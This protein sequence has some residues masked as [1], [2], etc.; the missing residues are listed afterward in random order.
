MSQPRSS[1]PVAQ[2][3]ADNETRYLRRQ[4][5]RLLHRSTCDFPGSQPITFQRHHFRELLREDYLVYEKTDGLRYLLLATCVPGDYDA[6]D[7][8][9]IDRRNN[10][11]KPASPTGEVSHIVRPSNP[12]RFEMGPGTETILDGEF[13]L[14]GSGADHTRLF[15]VFDSLAINGQS[16]LHH[17]HSVR[18]QKIKDYLGDECS[19]LLR[20][21]RDKSGVAVRLKT[22]LPS[23]K[24][25]D[26][27]KTIVPHLPYANDGLVF[28]NRESPYEFGTHPSTLKWKRASSTTLDFR[29][30]APPCSSPSD[31]NSFELQIHLGRG[32]HRKFASLHV[33]IDESDANRANAM[34]AHGKVIEC[35]CDGTGLWKPKMLPDG[36]FKTRLDKSRANHIV[37]AKD[38]LQYLQNP[39]TEDELAASGEA[40]RQA[41]KTRRQW[42]EQ[43][44]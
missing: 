17:S 44:L 41:W 16:I 20:H 28:V 24:A 13:V 30:L 32:V 10:Y 12:T 42:R 23:Y 1:L 5:A 26:M 39:I 8:L 25:H 27:L 21:L 37:V 22:P 38:I 15:L 29:L 3:L 14:Q 19:S 31:T 36:T 33:G 4:V 11:Y 7:V 34:R 6:V 9:L 40:I 35:F 2:K 43:R 18:R